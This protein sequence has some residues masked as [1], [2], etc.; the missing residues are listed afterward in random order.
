MNLLDITINS[1]RLKL[2]STSEI[3]AND[4]FNEFSKDLTV[5]MYPKPAEKIDETLSFINTSREKMEK[6]EQLQ[7]VILNKITGEFLGGTG[8][9]E[10]NTDTPELGIWI[11][12]SAHG[13]KYGREAVKTLKKWIDK[14]YS[15]K[16][17]IY[18]VD[19]RNLPSRK[20]AESLGGIIENE[21]AKENMQ[22]NIL[23]EV[24]YRIYPTN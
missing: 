2:V 5:F 24:E 17:I 3:Y 6:G 23:D 19:K 8:V 14:N 9:S 22:G 16:Y 11:K 18:P 20:I 7:V 13:H 4:I 10:L 1:D 15:Y 12:K 21:Y